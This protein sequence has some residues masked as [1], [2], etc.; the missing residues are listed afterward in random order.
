MGRYCP[1]CSE[2]RP[3]S[4]F[5]DK[6]SERRFCRR[7]ERTAPHIRLRAEK[8]KEQKRWSILATRAMAEVA[9]CRSAPN[10]KRSDL[11]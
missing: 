11:K 5:A 7:C 3:E 1:I 2:M 9:L 6:E 4:E 8:A 10:W